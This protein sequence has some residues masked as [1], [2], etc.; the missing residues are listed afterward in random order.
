MQDSYQT[1]EENAINE[2]DLYEL[3]LNGKARPTRKAKHLDIFKNARENSVS[4]IRSG[5]IVR[6]RSLASSSTSSEESSS[7]SS[8]SSSDEGDD[9][10]PP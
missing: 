9:D 2:L 10:N 8:S 3:A 4:L 1:N 6:S 7:E 5:V